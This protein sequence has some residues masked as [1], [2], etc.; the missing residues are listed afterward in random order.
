MNAASTPL[1][2][3]IAGLITSLHCCGMCG[4]LTGA[5]FSQQSKSPGAALI[6]YHFTRAL[7]YSL[8]G[9][10]LALAGAT[11]SLLFSS[12]PGRLLP[13]GFAAL[14][15]A[16]A[17]G[18]EK[19]IPQPRFVSRW[20]LRLNLF[21]RPRGLLGT[22]LGAM[23]PF[24]P[25]APLYLAFGVALLADSFTEGALLMAAFAAGTIP[26]YWLVQSQ[27]VRWST[28]WSPITLQRTRMALALVS[29]AM[30]IWRAALNNGL[31]EPACPLCH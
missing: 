22:L 5:L 9:G 26:F 25:C 28:R 6:F 12:T 16:Y 8:I 18:L 4:P 27:Y 23:T 13:W 17:L 7:S 1:A 3:F 30:L 15:I 31:A 11:A 2:A 14:F 29:A 24:L 21:A 10:L 19:K 20:L